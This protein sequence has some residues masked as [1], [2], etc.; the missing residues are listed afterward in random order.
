[1]EEKGYKRDFAAATIASGGALGMIIP[2]SLL[3]IFYGVAAQV[4]I[5]KLFMGGLIPGTFIMIVMMVG[6]WYVSRK[7]GYRG[8]EK[9][10]IKNIW[11]AFKTSI[12]ALLLPVII[13]GGIY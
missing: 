8:L 9:L 4:S 7:A 5:T 10:Q 2:P 13:L 3:M 11:K 6:A 12:W 1:M